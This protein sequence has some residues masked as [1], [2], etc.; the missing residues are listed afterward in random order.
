MPADLH[1]HTNHSDSTLT[2]AAVVA[3][4][5]AHGIRTVAITDHD[6]VDGVAAAAE[7]GRSAGLRVVPGVEMTAYDDRTEVH[8]VGLFVDPGNE[9]L[10]AVLRETREARRRRIHEIVALLGKLDV[11]VSADAVF[12]IAGRGSP[13]RPHVAQALVRSGRVSSVA[14]AFRYYLANGAPAYVPKHNL[15]P[16]EA[17]ATVHDAGGVS[18]LAHP[19]VGLNAATIARILQCNIDGV[20]VYHPLHSE[21]DTHRFLDMAHELRLLVSGGSDSHGGMRPETQIGAVLLP[22]ELVDRLEAYARR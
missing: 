15:T 10:E 7:A 11:E 22:D 5:L 14:D 12:E 19:G 6:S 17:A 13:G 20:E 4:C 8:I 18:V 9:R 1:V 21:G 3:E 16:G 2:P